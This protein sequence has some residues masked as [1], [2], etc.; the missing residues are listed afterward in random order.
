[1][2][3]LL[4][5]GH[6]VPW[7][8][9]PLNRLNPQNGLCLNMLHDKA[10]D[11]G[12]MYIDRNFII[13]YTDKFKERTTKKSEAFNWMMQFDGKPLALPRGFKPSPD[14]LAL[15]EKGLWRH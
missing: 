9:D 11:R 14:L 12:L 5:A 1:M 10:F 2:P 15:H 6:I 13:H 4:V 7:S 3:Q 8:E